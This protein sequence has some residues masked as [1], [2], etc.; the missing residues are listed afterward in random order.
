[1]NGG[2]PR[3]FGILDCSNMLGGIRPWIGRVCSLYDSECSH[4]L[5]LRYEFCT[6]KSLP[7][8]SLLAMFN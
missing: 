4:V 7:G 8:V 3:C 5:L 1:M 6:L 2:C